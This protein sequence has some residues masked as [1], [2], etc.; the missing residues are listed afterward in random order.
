[1]EIGSNLVSKRLLHYSYALFWRSIDVHCG[2]AY[3]TQAL[4]QRNGQ[5]MVSCTAY[6]N[7]PMMCVKT[8]CTVPIFENC[9]LYKG[10]TGYLVSVK[11]QIFQAYNN[12][13]QI[14]VWKGTDTAGNPISPHFACEWINATDPNNK[15]PHCKACYAAQYTP[16]E[17]ALCPEKPGY[18]EQ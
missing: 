16:F 1:M 9:I 14:D 10:R 18:P 17:Y 3:G 8:T 7:Q 5:D 15:R 6:G 12:C 13:S 11:P 4:P 2:N